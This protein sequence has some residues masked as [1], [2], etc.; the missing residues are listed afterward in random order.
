AALLALLFWAFRLAMGLRW[1]KVEREQARRRQLETGRR[2]VAEL[3][4]PEGVSFFSE[5]EA[6][7]HWEGRSLRREEV[8]GARL[9][10]N[11]AVVSAAARPGFALPDPPAPEDEPGREK[12]EVM[13]YLR[14]GQALTIRCG[15]V[16]EGVSRE[17]AR[18]VF[19]ALRREVQ[20]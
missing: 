20:A 2:V 16:R 1:A 17:A 6:A 10:L 8:A 4:L 14:N 18:A 3:P 5:D 15:S 12:W 11:S 13:A 9:L 7:L 19:D